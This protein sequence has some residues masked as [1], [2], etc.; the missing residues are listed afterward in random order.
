MK[1]PYCDEEAKTLRDDTYYL[2]TEDDKVHD[3]NLLQFHCP[4]EHIFYG[5][6][7]SYANSEAEQMKYLK[8][9]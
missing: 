1:C 5:H 7:E 6:K 3:D 8:N 4:N 9:M 2:M